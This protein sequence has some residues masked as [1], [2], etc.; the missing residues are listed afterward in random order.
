MKFNKKHYFIIGAIVVLTIFI[1]FQILFM[2][3][4]GLRPMTHGCFGIKINNKKI[5]RFFPNAELEFYIPFHFRYSVSQ[6]NKDRTP[7]CMGKDIWHGE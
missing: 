3:S 4:I 6:K 2:G 5:V 1:F 7:F